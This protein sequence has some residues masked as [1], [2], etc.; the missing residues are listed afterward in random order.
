MTEKQGSPQEFGVVV[1]RNVMMSARDG[2]E[3]GTD[4]YRP[5]L[6]AA[7]NPGSI[8]LTPDGLAAVEGAFPVILERTPYD[9]TGLGLRRKGHYYARRGM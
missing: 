1:D 6:P 2:I 9:K 5:A 8:G 7:G 4:V 3:L